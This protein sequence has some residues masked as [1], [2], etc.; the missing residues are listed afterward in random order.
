[1]LEGGNVKA[2]DIFGAPRKPGRFPASGPGTQTSMLLL[3]AGVDPDE[4]HPHL[5]SEQRR[6]FKGVAMRQEKMAEEW[7]RLH[8]LYK[9][10]MSSR[11]AAVQKIAK[12]LKSWF[13]SS[14]KGGLGNVGR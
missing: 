3:E 13:K 2:E 7:L 8:G 6:Q 5:R 1:L 4:A 10:C 12:R 9:L 14:P 11:D